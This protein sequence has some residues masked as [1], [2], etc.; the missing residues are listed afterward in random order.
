M[1]IDLCDFTNELC[2]FLTVWK[3]QLT[4]TLLFLCFFCV[5]ELAD[6]SRTKIAGRLTLTCLHLLIINKLDVA[7]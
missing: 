1:A 2:A 3:V 4:L 7:N 5:V 6:Q